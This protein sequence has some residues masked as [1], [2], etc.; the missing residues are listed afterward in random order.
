MKGISLGLKEA[1][2]LAPDY[3]ATYYLLGDVLLKEQDYAA[4]VPYFRTAIEKSQ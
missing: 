2:R 3:P 4:A 1:L